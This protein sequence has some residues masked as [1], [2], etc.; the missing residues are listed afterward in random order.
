MAEEA[1]FPSTADGI[2][3]S[4]LRSVVPGLGVESILSAEPLSG[5]FLG[6]V[7]KVEVKT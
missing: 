6:S 5:G 4:W 7:V 2:T 1:P 3:A